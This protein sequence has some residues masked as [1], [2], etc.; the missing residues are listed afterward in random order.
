MVSVVVIVVCPK[1]GKHGSLTSR[2]VKG[3][4]YEY[5][6]HFENGRIKWC[7]V[8]REG[9]FNSATSADEPVK[10]PEGDPSQESMEAKE[11]FAKL[12][13]W[14]S[15]R[16]YSDEELLRAILKDARND[17]FCGVGRIFINEAVKYYNCTRERLVKV[18]N[19]SGLK[20]WFGPGGTTI[21]IEL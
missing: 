13:D 15:K 9:T 8:G 11:Y 18:L 20:W 21:L 2:K 16:E 5:V 14:Y 17:Y 12:M 19:A 1:C 10:T 6:A 7:Y 3:K 4:R